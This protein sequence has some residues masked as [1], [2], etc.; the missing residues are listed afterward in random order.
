M[1]VTQLCLI[2]CNSIEKSME[3]S[4]TESWRWVAFPF[5]LERDLPNQGSNPGL[6]QYRGILYQLSQIIFMH[7]PNIYSTH[8][9]YQA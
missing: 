9:V 1:K 5:S 3:F 7:L 6:L 8:T 2:L 4:Q